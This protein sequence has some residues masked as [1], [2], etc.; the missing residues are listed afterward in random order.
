[1]HWLWQEHDHHHQQAGGS[2]YSRAEIYPFLM[3]LPILGF[4]VM[5]FIVLRDYHRQGESIIKV[6]TDS[7]PLPDA[8][9]QTISDIALS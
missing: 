6:F 8:P 5:K 1:M 3:N 9:R 4:L 2:T 7:L